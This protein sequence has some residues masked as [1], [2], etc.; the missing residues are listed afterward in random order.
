MDYD[1]IVVGSGIAGLYAALLAREHGTVLVLTKGSVDDCNTRYAQGGIAA[2]IGPGDS[3]QLHLDDT[4]AAGAGLVDPEAARVLAEEAADRIHDLVRFGV[5]FDTLHG[6]IALAREGAHSVSRILHAGG[7]STG[8]HI[9]LTL[10]SVAR[11]T[12]ITVLEFT[13]ATE[14]LLDGGAARAHGHAPLHRAVGGVRAL[15]ARSGRSTDYGC[16]HLVLAT[17][18][19]GQLYRVTTNP[20]VASGNGIA[21]AYRAGAQVMDMEFFQFHPTALRLP[22]VQPFLISEAV[23]GEGGILLDSGG[24][25]FMPEYDDRAELAPRDI[26]ARAIVDRMQVTGSDHVLLDVTHLDRAAVTAHFPQIYRT[27]LEHGLDITRQPIPVSPAA[28]YTMG[29]I[30]SN[31][32]GE[33]SISGLYACGECACTGVHGANRLA[34]NSLLETV[35]FAKRVID[36]TV[37]APGGAAEAAPDAIDLSPA[38]AAEAPP[39]SREALQSLMWDNVGIVRDGDSLSR[40]RAALRAWDAALPPPTDRPSHELADLVVC[41]RLVTEAA[42]IREESRGAHYR[43]DFPEPREEW[44]RH[45]VFRGGAGS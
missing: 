16:R 28:H 39:V 8:A 41:G 18:G 45:I 20:E 43:S 29:G 12:G 33:T 27:C 30:R 24:A 31:L 44:R 9:E 35:V 42:L 32:W 1:Y 21:L 37:Q 36:R 13:L 4:I 3:P 38:A 34:S 14:I 11:Q 25:R 2:P 6:E 26:V 19:A 22:G 5:P 40:A 7:D 10:S 15:D 23:R 17:G